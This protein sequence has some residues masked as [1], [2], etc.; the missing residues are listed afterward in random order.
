MRKPVFEFSNQAR[1]KPA[2]SAAEA[3]SSLETLDIASIG[4]ILSKQQT[5]KVLIRL[6]GCAG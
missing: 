4:I 2:C 5:T 3:S 6:C 1:L